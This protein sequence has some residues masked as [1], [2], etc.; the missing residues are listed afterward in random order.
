MAMSRG[1]YSAKWV[2]GSIG[3]VVLAGTVALTSLA[4]LAADAAKTPVMTPKAKR[5]SVL[6]QQNCVSCHNKEAN[7]TTPFGPPNLHGIFS[8]KPL[9]HPAL[10]PAE[11]ADFIRKGKAPMP[12]FGGML[13]EAQI[14]DLIAYL[15][16]Q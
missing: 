15:K 11:A 3:L 2:R 16:V 8:A 6:F 12:A 13:T 7:D 9:V 1:H 14:G 10:T 5:G 4:G